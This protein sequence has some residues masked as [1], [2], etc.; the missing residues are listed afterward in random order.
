MVA[1]IDD[2]WKTATIAV[3]AVG[4]AAVVGV[5]GLTSF[6]LYKHC[7]SSTQVEQL[8]SEPVDNPVVYGSHA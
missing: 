1:S 2:K 3:A 4:G 7:H 5:V 6:L 8:R